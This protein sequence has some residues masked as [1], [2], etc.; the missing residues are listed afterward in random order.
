LRPEKLDIIVDWRM[1]VMKKNVLITL[2]SF[3]KIIE[4]FESPVFLRLPN[5]CDYRDVYHELKVKKQKLEIRKRYANVIM[6]EDDDSRD[7][8]RI[9]YLRMKSRLGK[10]DIDDIFL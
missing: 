6:A 3:D 5:Y 2:S 9:E 4:L 8:A 1:F 7:D 10:I